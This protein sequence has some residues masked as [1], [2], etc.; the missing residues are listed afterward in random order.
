MTSGEPSAGLAAHVLDSAVTTLAAAGV[1]SPRSDAEQLAAYVTGEPRWRLRRTTAIT[2]ADQDR[3]QDRFQDLVARRAA[4][5]PLQHLVGSVGFRYLTLAVGPGVFI[6]R[7]ETE[8]V[9]G[10]A[11]DAVRA[12][13]W[14]RPICVDLCTGSGAI[15]LALAEELPGACVHAVDVDPEA[16]VW[17]GRNIVDHGFVGTDSRVTLHRAD[18]GIDPAGH[19]R[20][21]GRE[22]A[23]AV[24]QQLADLVG[25]VD[26]VVSNPPYLWDDERDKVDPE[27]GIHDP[28]AALWAGPDGLAGVRAVVRVASDLLRDGGKLVIEHSD[29]HG[30]AVPAL[31]R[32]S[33][34][35]EDVQDH[36]DLAG[37]DR[38]VSA[39]RRSRER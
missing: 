20:N 22:P 27:V 1:P 4:R 26:L 29:R 19:G 37:R 14:A 7:P 38:F 23:T 33:G 32:D 36:L 31:L 2:L 39:S 21:D 13:G 15:A 17:A 3:F 8:V 16:L 18:V 24:V 5:V 34:C 11:L 30:S 35:W 12:A 28:P 9:V 6:P 10:W 25:R